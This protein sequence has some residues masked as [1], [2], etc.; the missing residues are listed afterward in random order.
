MVTLR[1]V[2]KA[3]GVSLSTAS[4]VVNG[5]KNVNDDTR[6]KVL[7]A[8]SDLN[9]I[10]YESDN[11]S[12]H[13]IATV[14]PKSIGY[15]MDM[16]N[17]TYRA[18]CGIT[19]RCNREKIKNMLILADE[20][21]LDFSSAFSESISAFIFVSSGRFEENTIIPLLIER[22]VPIITLNRRLD[23]KNISFVDI[24]D[25]SASFDAVKYLIDSGHEKIGFVSGSYGSQSTEERL[26][27]YRSAL[28][29]ENID[30]DDAYIYLC[31]DD[32]ETAG[33][34][35]AAYFEKSKNMPSAFM[36][37][38]DITA[39]AMIREFNSLGISVPDDVSVMGFGDM[40]NMAYHSPSLTT[41]RI[42]PEDMGEEAADIAVKLIN[43]KKKTAICSYM[44]Y[45]LCIRESVSDKRRL[46]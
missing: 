1:D 46:K 28:Q 26:D 20:S 22:N 45:E 39:R 41:V 32:S 34:S 17:I 12:E 19:K 29:S 4:R 18:I 2:A 16:Y 5:Y 9:Y 24:D 27:G 42:F 13:I 36:V 11:L 37:S 38:S 30:C 23:Y 43:D 44:G 8:I 31:N 3:A 33:C 15:N 21:D 40:E 14:I 25:K 35:A 6:K 10:I 7:R